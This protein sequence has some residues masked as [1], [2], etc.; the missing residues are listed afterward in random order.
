MKKAKNTSKPEKNVSL[1][2]TLSVEDRDRLDALSSKMAAAYGLSL[3]AFTRAGLAAECCL[4]GL[5]D[6]EDKFS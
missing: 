3:A 1:T 2:I 4:L 5:D 6:L